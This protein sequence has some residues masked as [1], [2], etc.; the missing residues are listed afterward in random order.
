MRRDAKP[1]NFSILYGTSA[2]G[3]AKKQKIT[4]K[5]AEDIIETFYKGYP[6]LAKFQ[7]AFQEFA[8]KNMYSVS[9]YGR[10]RFAENRTLFADMKEK[11]KYFGRLKREFFNHVIQGTAADI[12]KL[13]LCRLYHENPFGEGM[14]IILTVH[15]EIEISVKEELAEQ[16]KAFLKKVMEEEEQK[17]LG[18]IPA[19]AEVEYGKWWVH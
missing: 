13:I 3:M 4:Q 7:P 11:D 6:T 2:Y 10:K 14:R 5:Q 12:V 18:E 15:D 16:G 17:F 8:I 1:V 19:V 9:L